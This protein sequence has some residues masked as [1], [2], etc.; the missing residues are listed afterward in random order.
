MTVR[1]PMIKRKAAGADSSGAS[2]P[3]APGAKQSRASSSAASQPAPPGAKQSGASRALN[4]TPW[5]SQEHRLAV[6]S[7]QRAEKRRRWRAFCG[8]R[9]QS[10]GSRNRRLKS[11]RGR[12]TKWVKTSGHNC[13][14]RTPVHPRGE[15]LVHVVELLHELGHRHGLRWVR[16]VRHRWTRGGQ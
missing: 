10:H 13:K 3:V 7:S 2:Q 14:L 6:G 15:I 4:G 1:L 16:R 12:A 11:A 5:S 9:P 8:R